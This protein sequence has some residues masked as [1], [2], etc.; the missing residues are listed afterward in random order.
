MPRKVRKLPGARST[1]AIEEQNKLRLDMMRLVAGSVVHADATAAPAVTATAVDL[2]TAIARL[3]AI[4]AAYGIHIGSE[5]SATTG[6]GA[7][8]AADVSNTI[9]APAAG[10]G[11][12]AAAI[13]LANEI[14]AK[15]ELHRVRLASHPK[16]DSAT[17][18][19]SADA[20]D[21]A[22]L[23]TLVNELGDDVAAHIAAALNSQA[24][25]L[26]AP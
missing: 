7:H 26:V 8:I 18:I 11:D 19:T 22:T 13:T 5:C 21:L 10:A 12:Q 25:K 15:H 24:I 4:L 16:A 20:S 9:A 2:P 6:Q 14:K 1:A 23:I 17:A 3:N